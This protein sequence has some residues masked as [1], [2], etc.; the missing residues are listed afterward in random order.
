[1]KEAVRA[2]A[3]IVLFLLIAPARAWIVNVDGSGGF[4][5][6]HAVVVDATGD[7]V[8]GGEAREGGDAGDFTVL[9]LARNDGHERWR[10]VLSDSTSESFV[11][12][13]ALATGTVVAGGR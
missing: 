5:S 6:G 9:K 13:L 10:T 3:A 8:A 1:M 12:A 7:V 11:A 4:S 2:A